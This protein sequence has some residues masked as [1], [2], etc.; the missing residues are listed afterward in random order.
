MKT[1]WKWITQKE[2]ETTEE[3]LKVV[4]TTVNTQNYGYGTEVL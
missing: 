1:M 2:W 4:G 3:E